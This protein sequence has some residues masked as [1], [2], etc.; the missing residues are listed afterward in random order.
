MQGREWS[1]IENSTVRRISESVICLQL[2]AKM[3]GYAS[4]TRPT[5]V[6]YFGLVKFTSR[7]KLN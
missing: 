2:A 3:A 1:F 7:L 5:S 4:L 6:P